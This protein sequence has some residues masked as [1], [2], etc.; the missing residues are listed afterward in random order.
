MSSTSREL[1]YQTLNFQSPAR[2][3]RDLWVLPIA[4]ES[5]PK[6]YNEI[7]EAF[8]SDF[9]T[10]SGHERAQACTKGDPYRVGEYVDPWGCQT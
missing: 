2:A 10:I 1:V 3:P 8:P 4:T 7:L 6:E 5:H 9:Q